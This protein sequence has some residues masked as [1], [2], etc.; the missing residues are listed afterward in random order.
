VLGEKDVIQLFLKN[1][2]QISKKALPL[3]MLEPEKILSNLKNLDPKP[4]IITKDHI[5]G[6]GKETATGGSDTKTLVVYEFLEGP[7]EISDYVNFFSS[8]Y[9]KTKNILLKHMLDD[10]IISINK[11]TKQTSSF[12]IIGIVRNKSNYNML[13]EDPSGEV[14]IFFNESVPS[15]SDKIFLDD[16][17][18]VRC[19]K[20]GE[21][22][23]VKK[24]FF[25]DI[26]SSRRVNKTKQE[27][28]I[29]LIFNPCKLYPEKYKKIFEFLNS[30]TTPPFIFVFADEKNKK[31]FE[32]FSRF[33]SV[34]IHPKSPP[35]LFGLSNI[36]ILSLTNDF[37]KFGQDRGGTFD[38]LLSFL[39][40]RTIPL[41]CD[42]MRIGKGG[43]VLE[44]VPNIIISN[45]N[46]TGQ[47][48]YKGTT[49]VSNSS[50][51]KIFIINLKNR[52]VSKKT[53]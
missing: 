5:L 32:D 49:L 40:R 17:V 25:P 28:K 38:F 43:F 13:L 3:V 36:K 19:K 46:E 33:K 26:L 4:F 34:F 23:Y 15:I 11:I 31:T 50:P 1:K 21:K 41:E 29:I 24:I 30:E 52:E 53:L 20:I 27:I 35:T 44:Q 48:N 18:G 45:F 12:S 7:L 8:R 37:F 10:K 2:F 39:K 42:L 51:E 16:V 9:E 6:L 14:H 47:M 22:I